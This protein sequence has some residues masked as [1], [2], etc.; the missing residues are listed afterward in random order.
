MRNNILTLLS[1]I[2]A[3]P[4]VKNSPQEK[5]KAQVMILGAYHMDNPNQD[6][7]KT[8]VDDHLSQKRQEQIAEVA[9]LLAKFKPTKIV[10]EAVEGVTSIH[11]S[12]ESYL[13]RVFR[14]PCAGHLRRRP[15]AD[16]PRVDSEQPRPST[17][18]AE[19]LSKEAVIDHWQNNSRR[20]LISAHSTG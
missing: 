7:V 18:R 17:G 12:Y 16:T 14:R 9:A 10:L 8:N 20:V 15:C 4:A 11:R 5:K 19:R 2:A 6:Y 13:N 1:N 3:R